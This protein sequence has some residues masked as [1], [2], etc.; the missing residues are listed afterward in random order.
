M[1]KRSLILSIIVMLFIAT[2]AFAEVIK[3]YTLEGQWDWVWSSLTIH[4]MFAIPTAFL[5]IWIAAE[6]MAPAGTMYAMWRLFRMAANRLAL[7]D[8]VEVAA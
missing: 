2:N 3:T 1:F 6:E 7:P 5:W 4:L 8:E